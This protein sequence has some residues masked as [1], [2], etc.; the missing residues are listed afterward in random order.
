VLR[1]D[2]L[3]HQHGARRPV[4]AEA[5]AQS[6]QGA[7]VAEL[8]KD[9]KDE[10]VSLVFHGDDSTPSERLKAFLMYGDPSNFSDEEEAEVLA[11]VRDACDRASYVRRDLLTEEQRKEHDALLARIRR[12]RALLGKFFDA[13]MR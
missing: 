11:D 2:Y 9:E 8:T 6:F 3:A 12:G 4:P 5:E 1:L 7:N 13:D 10:L